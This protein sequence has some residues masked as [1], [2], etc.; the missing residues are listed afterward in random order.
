MSL[1]VNLFELATLSN[2]ERTRL[3]NRT[4]TDL[5]PYESKVRTIIDAVRK[6]G[7]EALARFAREF[8]RAPVDAASLAATAFV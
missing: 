2:A 1:T 6:D 7:D 3:L 4:E 8:D 5:T